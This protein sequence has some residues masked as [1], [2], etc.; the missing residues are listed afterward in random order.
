MGERGVEG[1]ERGRSKGE[2]PP[3]SEYTLTLLLAH[4]VTRQPTIRH[5]LGRA[6]RLPGNL[7]YRV[8]C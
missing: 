7:G 2:E 6:F 1:E 5:F 4:T 3:K 8:L